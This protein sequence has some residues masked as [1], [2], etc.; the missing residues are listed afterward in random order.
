M[1]KLTLLWLQKAGIR[2]IKTMGQAALA[3]IVV[4]APVN[5]INWLNVGAVALTAG[6]VSLLTSLKGL[7][8]V[9]MI[10]MTKISR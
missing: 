7:P 10:E 8:E 3:V 6:I 2:A 1:K 5:E 4:G 9:D